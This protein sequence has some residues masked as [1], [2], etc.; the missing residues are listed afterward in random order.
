A[1]GELR[2][3][4]EARGRRGAQADMLIAATA[5]THGLTLATRNGRDFEGCGVSVVDPFGGQSTKSP[6]TTAM[7]G[8]A[9]HAWTP[10]C[11]KTGPCRNSW[12]VVAENAFTRRSYCSDDGVRRASASR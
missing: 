12:G 3:A 2:A 8:R 4:R 6:H 9:L 11:P 10:C 1:S 5:L 7:V